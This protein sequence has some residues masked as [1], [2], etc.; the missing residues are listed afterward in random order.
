MPQQSSRAPG[1]TGTYGIDPRARYCRSFLG[2][3]VRFA[4]ADMMPYEGPVS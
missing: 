4:T 2:A 1:A 3:N